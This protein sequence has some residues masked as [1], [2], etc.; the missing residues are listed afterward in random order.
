VLKSINVR[1]I[2]TG[3]LTLR[4]GEDARYSVARKGQTAEKPG[5]LANE[6]LVAEQPDECGCALEA[7]RG[8]GDNACAGPAFEKH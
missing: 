8:I 7:G 3:L 6:P 5:V 4:S 1:F 2:Y